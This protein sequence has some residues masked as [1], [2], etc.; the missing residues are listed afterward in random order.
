MKV[1]NTDPIGYGMPDEA[2]GLFLQGNH[3]YQVAP[4][5]RNEE[6]ERIA[7]FVDRD[8]MQSGWL[9][10][11]EHIAKKAAVVSV[12]YGQGKVVLIGFRAQHRVQTHGTF[13]FVFNALVGATTSR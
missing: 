2:L 5:A 1:D 11:E 7:T 8:I 10:G 6:I 12:G 3:A 4:S 13:K 9:V